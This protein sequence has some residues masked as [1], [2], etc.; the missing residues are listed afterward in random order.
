MS[1][2]YIIRPKFF[3]PKMM[4]GGRQAEPKAILFRA[5]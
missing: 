1:E 4:T 5:G 3:H 2:N